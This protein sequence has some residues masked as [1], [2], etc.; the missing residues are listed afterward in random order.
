VDALAYGVGVR[1]VGMP[2]AGVGAKWGDDDDDPDFE[3]T[4]IERIFAD[5]TLPSGAGPLHITKSLLGG[6]D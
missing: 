5:Y 1:H 6:G 3:P 2:Y 4:E